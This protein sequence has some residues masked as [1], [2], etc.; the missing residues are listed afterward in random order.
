MGYGINFKPAGGHGGFRTDLEMPREQS[1]TEPLKIS[2]YAPKTEN[3]ILEVSRSLRTE[4][5][6][7]Q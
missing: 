5:L 1:L 6:P 4:R 7:D 3:A 2:H